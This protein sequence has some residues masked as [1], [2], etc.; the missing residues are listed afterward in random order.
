MAHYK[1]SHRRAL[2]AAGG[3][4]LIGA[5][6]QPGSRLAAT[7][8]GLGYYVLASDGAVFPFGDAPD[9]GDPSA[10]GVS[11]VDLGVLGGS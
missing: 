4:F 9:F 7:A 8:T 5:A 2:L 10:L 11:A 6:L 1:V 3:S